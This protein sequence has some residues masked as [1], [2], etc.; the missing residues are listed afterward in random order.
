MCGMCVMCGVWCVCVCVVS[1]CVG[2]GVYVL[3]VCCL[4]SDVFVLSV[5][6]VCVWSVLCYLCV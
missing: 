3:C 6:V 4:V 5:F 1:L 2:C